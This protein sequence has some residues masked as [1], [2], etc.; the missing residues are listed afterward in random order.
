MPTRLQ[1]GN[2]KKKTK[3]TTETINV[4]YVSKE[5]FS[6]DYEHYMSKIW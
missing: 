4:C 6:L 1:K 3:I 5:R 2:T